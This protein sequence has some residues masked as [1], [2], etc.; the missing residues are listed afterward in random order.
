M[1]LVYMHTYACLK[2][3]KILQDTNVNDGVDGEIFCV[4]YDTDAN[5]GCL[6]VHVCVCVCVCVYL[7]VCLRE[8]ERMHMLIVRTSYCE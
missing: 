3:I 5:S 7:C 8:N 4:F 6:C 2:D 1:C